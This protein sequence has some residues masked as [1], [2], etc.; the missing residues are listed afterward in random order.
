MIHVMNFK[1]TNKMDMIP[2]DTCIKGMIIASYK[3]WRDKERCL[4][5]G[6]NVIP[7]YNATSL[8]HVSYSSLNRTSDVIRAQPSLNAFGTPH[9]TFSACIYYVWILR[10]FRH[11]IPAVLVDILLRISNNKPRYLRILPCLALGIK[12]SIFLG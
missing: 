11:I 3:T 4:K 9:V 6:G 10:I 2:V 5:D 7:V 12:K 8:R 1:G